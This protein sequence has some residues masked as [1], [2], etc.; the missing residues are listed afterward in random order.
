MRSR[1]QVEAEKMDQMVRMKQER[2]VVAQSMVLEKRD[3][4][5]EKVKTIDM[6]NRS[7]EVEQ[8]KLMKQF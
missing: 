7:L 5:F 8:I 3:K 1:M 4:E 6:M 2:E